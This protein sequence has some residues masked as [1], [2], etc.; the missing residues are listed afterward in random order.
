MFGGQGAKR[1][2]FRDMEAQL[3][4]LPPL[5]HVA[6]R[7][8]VRSLVRVTE[9]ALALLPHLKEQH[10]CVPCRPLLQTSGLKLTSLCCSAAKCSSATLGQPIL[11]P[12]MRCPLHLEC[13]KTSS[14]HLSLGEDLAF[15]TLA[16]ALNYYSDLGLHL[17]FYRPGK[18]P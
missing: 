4:S 15:G 14:L 9:H 16:G 1:W 17:P 8:S 5:Q 12:Q 2:H 18:P 10:A 7:A 11:L 6:S 3:A 13:V